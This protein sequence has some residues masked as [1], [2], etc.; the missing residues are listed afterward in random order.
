MDCG[1]SELKRDFLLDVS[2][3]DKNQCK[4]LP[5][6][7][8]KC[9][10][11]GGCINEDSPFESVYVEEEDIVVVE[12]Q[13]N[14][15]PQFSEYISDTSVMNISVYISEEAFLAVQFSCFM[16]P[17]LNDN[18][19][20]IS[21]L[22]HCCSVCYKNNIYNIAVDFLEKKCQASSLSPFFPDSDINLKNKYLNEV[23]I[24][25]SC[26]LQI[27]KKVLIY[28]VFIRKFRYLDFVKVRLF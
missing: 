10:D 12:E 1:V 26:I 5:N 9:S 14:I 19:P 11:F 13:T 8:I 3:A 25:I 16:I 21:F 24:G 22:N 7:P 4:I 23:R 6:T 15:L 27:V 20:T 18:L 17:R 28:C 2:I